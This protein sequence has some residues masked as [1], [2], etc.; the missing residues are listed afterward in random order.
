[1]TPPTIRMQYWKS[2]TKSGKGL[3][4]RLAIRCKIDGNGIQPWNPGKNNQYLRRC[5]MKNGVCPKCNSTEVYWSVGGLKA[6]SGEC[7]LEIGNWSNKVI[8][9]STYLCTQCGYT[10]MYVADRN[11]D[12][13]SALVKEKDWG[14]VK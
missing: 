10:E 14:K 3:F 6:G 12:K 7:H 4:K 8:F 1:M 9:L 11:M 13:L 5:S 2:Y